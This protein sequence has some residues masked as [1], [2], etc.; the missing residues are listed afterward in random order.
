MH[1]WPKIS[2]NFYAYTPVLHMHHWDPVPSRTAEGRLKWIQSYWSSGAALC[3]ILHGLPRFF[4]SFRQ[5][6]AFL[7]FYSCFFSNFRLFGIQNVYGR[8][9]LGNKLCMI[10]WGHFWTFVVKQNWFIWINKTEVTSI[11]FS[12]HFLIASIRQYD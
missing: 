3:A 5:K 4:H 1:G 8:I 9:F 12:V 7:H 10:G 6:N 2:I 11:K